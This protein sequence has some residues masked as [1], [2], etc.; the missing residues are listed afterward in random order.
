M[1]IHC[2][3]DRLG[4]C[5]CKGLLGLVAAAVVGGEIGGIGQDI[6]EGDRTVL[7]MLRLLPWLT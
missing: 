4:S 7:P 6:E 3:L 2:D 5:L 1:L